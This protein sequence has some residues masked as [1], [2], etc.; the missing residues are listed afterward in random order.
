MSAVDTC[1]W[2][3]DIDA[4]NKRGWPED[5][6]LSQTSD[7]EKG[8]HDHVSVCKTRGGEV[9]VSSNPPENLTR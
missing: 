9:R 5:L 7:T 1:T 6:R 8:G 2:G 4:T 3:F